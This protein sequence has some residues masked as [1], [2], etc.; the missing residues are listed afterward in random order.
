M[1]TLLRS[2]TSFDTAKEVDDYPYGSLRTKI[3]YWVE[4][5]EKG[6]KK[7]EERPVSC[8]LNPKTGRWNK[9]HPGTY[10]TRVYMYS[11]IQP[12]GREFV[13]W[14]HV[15]ASYGIHDKL[16]T[17][18]NGLYNQM[19]EEERA[20]FDTVFRRWGKYCGAEYRAEW[21]E[22][23]RRLAQAL[24]AFPEIT[25]ET[26]NANYDHK[27]YE[28]DGRALLNVLRTMGVSWLFPWETV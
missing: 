19:T 25:I 14:H 28:D 20:D 26:F 10:A 16:Y 12:D 18:S 7:G 13:K 5:A 21:E 17:L 27:I 15:S 11:E 4:R 23:R 1:L 22:K 8:T 2:H 3:R 9:P 24:C 6:A